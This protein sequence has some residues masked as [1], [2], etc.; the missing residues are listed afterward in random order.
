[1]NVRKYFGDWKFYRM[2]LTIA[3]PIMI[4]N[5]ITNFVSLLDNVM[6][7]QLGTEAMS[8]VSIVNNLIF[9]FYLLIFGAISS[10]GIFTAQY[11]GYKDI[12]GVRYTFRFKFI[13]IMIASLAALAA[14]GLAGD[15]LISLF[16]HESESGSD[17]ELTMSYA[18]NY[19]EIMLI[20]LV[21]YAISQAYASTLRETG[22]TILPMIGSI[23]AVVTN[24]VLNY[25]LIFGRFGAPVM[26]VEGAAVATVTSRFIELA[27]LVIW[28]HANKA[29]CPFIKGAYRS[30]YIPAA[31]TKEIVIKGLPLLFNELMWSAGVTITTQ[32]YSTR[33]LDVVAAL[34]ISTTINNVFNVIYLALGSAIAIVVGNLLG[35]AKLDEAR[36]TDRKMIAF[37]VM[38]SLVMGVLLASFSGLIP[39]MYNTTDEVRGLATYMMIVL[40]CVMPFGAY[41]HGAY[42]TL[43]SGGRV[44]ITLLFDSV[45]MWAVVIPVAFILSRATSISILWLYPI[46]HGLEILKAVFGAVILR[47]CNWVKQLVGNR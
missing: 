6:V 9:V 14:F 46:C 11:H 37:S 8:A 18:R 1:M 28:T 7:G 4:Q 19:L 42:F 31:L 34:N 27:I 41:A 36:D 2:V 43:R 40:A 16:L 13:I 12:N 26:G 5:G 3:V 35:A 39:L 24:F 47:K 32:C 38:C 33:G 21:P 23:C 29:K 45:Y 10:A 17:L 20:G 25:V 15:G 22:K 30:A 44:M